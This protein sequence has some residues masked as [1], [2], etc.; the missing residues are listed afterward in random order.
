MLDIDWAGIFLPNTPLLEIFVRGT[1]VY[2]ALF[3]MLRFVMRREAG[4]LGLTDLLVIVLIADAAQNAMAG[5]YTSI[6]D[7]ILLV[8]TIVFWSYVLSALA[9]HSEF[10]RRI[11]QPPRIQLVANGR[12]LWRHMEQQKIT[13][14]ELM[15]ELRSHGCDDIGRVRAVY[16][17]SDGMISVI[18]ARGE[19]NA[20]P[21]KDG[22]A[23]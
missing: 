18:T 4:T 16:M 23:V 7:G 8:A 11:V 3:A 17:E 22:R 6:A 21:K 20:S 1:V 14:E 15:G 9:F 10:W 5:E 13:E 19:Q 12:I 2:F